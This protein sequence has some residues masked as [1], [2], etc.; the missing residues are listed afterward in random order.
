MPPSVTLN[1]PASV[2]LPTAVYVPRCVAWLPGAMSLRGMQP[3]G[4]R[5]GPGSGSAAFQRTIHDMCDVG[6]E[7]ERPEN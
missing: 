7:G 2:V 5:G 1:V 6:D 3:A 4:I